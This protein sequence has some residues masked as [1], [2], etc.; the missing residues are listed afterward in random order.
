MVFV[1]KA[2]LK[3]ETRRLTFDGR[4]FPAYE[5]VQQKLRT[6]FNLPSTTHTYWVNVLLFPDDAHDSRIKFKQHVC[7]AYEYEAAQ[8]PFLHARLP[9]PALVFTILLTSDPRLSTIHTFHR[10][11]TLLE[12]AIH[13][14]MN[15]VTLKEDLA[16][17][18]SLLSSLQ[19]KLAACVREEDAV[20]M[21]FWGE[22]VQE[23]QRLVNDLRGKI[24]KCQKEHS[25]KTAQ[26][27]SHAPGMG[28]S[29]GGVRAWVE[30]EEKE[31]DLKTQ[32]T[33]DELAAWNAANE[34]DSEANLFPP[35]ESFL[36]A[37]PH[38]H[39][40]GGFGRHGRR[41]GGFSAW[42][43]PPPVF[44]GTGPW[45][46]PHGHPPHGFGH[47]GGP[48]PR[49]R[50]GEG[51]RSI[52]DRVS[53]VVSHQAPPSSLVPTQEIKAMLDGFL[54][55]L[56][57]QLAGTFEG[58]SAGTFEGGSAHVTTD[59][60]EDST[61]AGPEAERP[62]PGAFV[63]PPATQTDVQTQ[64][65]PAQEEKGEIE[66]VVKPCSR[67]GKGGFRHKHISCDGCLTGIRGM[68]YKCDQCPDYDLCGSCLPLLH[69]SDL[70]PASHTFTAMLHG[71]L[72]DR[73][74]LSDGE[75][76]KHPAS[77]DLCS[78]SIIG[79]RW[80]CLN[81]PD[82]DCCSSCSASI[83]E[84]HP[85]HSFVRLHKAAD[86][87]SNSDDPA[88]NVRH[89]HVVCD[90]CE[91]QIRGT[92]FKCMHPLCPDYDLCEK[93]ESAPLAIH[94][95]DH[96]M[97]KMKI[98]LRVDNQSVMEDAGGAV[99]HQQKA[100][101]GSR[102]GRHAHG[103]A[104]GARHGSTWRQSE[105]ESPMRQKREHVSCVA[106]P[107]VPGGYVSRNIYDQDESV[108]NLAEPMIPDIKSAAEPKSKEEPI[109]SAVESFF[110]ALNLIVDAHHD[111]AKEIQQAQQRYS[112][113]MVDEKPKGFEIEAE[114][115]AQ[116]VEE[117]VHE[118]QAPAPAVEVEVEVDAEAKQ[119]TKAREPG[120]PLDIFSW[121]RHATI[122]PGCI[123]P[124][125][126]EF[127]KTWKVKHFASGH[128][129]DFAAVK[130]VYQSEGNGILGEKSDSEVA[131]VREDIKEGEEM[132]I[133]LDGLRVPNAP[134]EEVVECW[135]FEDEAGVQ[136]G[137]PLRI[138][139]RVE[140]DR[141]RNTSMNSSA[142]IM[143]PSAPALTPA[144][145]VA[146]SDRDD[147][148]SINSDDYGTESDF[149]TLDGD[150]T[151]P[152]ES[153]DGEYD[154]VDEDYEETGDEL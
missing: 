34:A 44:P 94:P 113:A 11:K 4:R 106:N 83:T 52:F 1:I 138:R 131:Y 105:S 35:L 114:A 101:R 6:I 68:R 115:K 24:E 25:D 69:T 130:L 77:C 41:S 70:H 58:G 150:G 55:N 144:V 46:P 64:T 13:L 47:P 98:P 43:G 16:N 129:Y 17:R 66:K 133:T 103:D 139:F 23:K 50:Q 29:S 71:G 31:E 45:G 100:G 121:V 19:N 154:F 90:G 141:S 26:L 37:P 86:Y 61:S 5:E 7:D 142:V 152:S 62:I 49:G 149:M 57:N 93:C 14:S 72:G 95:D 10:A 145:S 81:C 132:E 136:Y 15:N 78:R 42:A 151:A 118:V 137:Q 82:W 18:V 33:L 104:F 102:K 27:D 36:H 85:G 123:L 88:K 127:T 75:S 73:I 119:D 56:S 91:G 20:G 92:R 96:P 80:K 117:P 67:L 116:Q 109:P 134:G 107:V 9:A 99:Y 22:R 60:T 124:P 21:A 54:A 153:H 147:V 65:P 8:P 48:G 84:K 59:T 146:S 2:T 87:V 97:L 28:L 125:G 76:V 122:P 39:P 3:D 79:V 40:Y 38:H 108:G 53:D 30:S 110:S 126:A 32:E 148:I 111:S 120:T 12:S 74:K 140:E 89:P 135:R 143:P 51:F 128:E 112:E 63:Q